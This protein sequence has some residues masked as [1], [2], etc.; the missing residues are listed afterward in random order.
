M[1]D[2]FEVSGID[3]DAGI[4]NLDDKTRLSESGHVAGVHGDGATGGGELGGVAEEVPDDLLEA[5]G[6]GQDA[7]VTRGEVELEVNSGGFEDIAAGEGRAPD[8]GVGVDGFWVHVEGAAADA[9][10]IKEVVYEAGFEVDVA[11]G[12]FEGVANLGGRPAFSR[13]AETSV[14][15]GLSGVRS[16][17]L[18]M[19][20][21]WSLAR[22]ASSA[23][24]RALWR[25]ST[26]KVIKT[27]P[28][29]KTMIAVIRQGGNSNWWWKPSSGMAAMTVS[30]VAV[31]PGPRPPYQAAMRTARKRM[32]VRP[33]PMT[34]R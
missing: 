2:A 1:K 22:L 25:A 15:T 19:A 6:I 12:H 16:S 31:R 5:G 28:T 18:R 33:R 13:R 27:P 7:G 9:G 14:R 29:A 23:R 20:R 11:P 26:S 8:Q 32:L 3:S 24:R 10:D 34:G 17:W 4:G 21:K 30:A